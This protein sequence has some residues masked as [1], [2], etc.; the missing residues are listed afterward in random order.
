M[1][2]SETF[3]KNVA[4]NECATHH[5]RL[6]NACVCFKKIHCAKNLPKMPNILQDHY[7]QTQSSRVFFK[8]GDLENFFKIHKNPFVWSLFLIKLQSSSAQLYLKKRL[9]HRRFPM[10][11]VKF[12][13]TPPGDCSVF[14][15]FKGCFS[16]CISFCRIL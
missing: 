6:Y 13:R 15:Y 1:T 14:H 7:I 9:Q 10:N 16:I 5:K 2:S 4:I 12:S 8:K 11:F 3:R